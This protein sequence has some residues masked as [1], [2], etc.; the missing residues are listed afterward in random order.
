VLI[1]LRADLNDMVLA[2]LRPR[3]MAGANARRMIVALALATLPAVV[4]GFAFKDAV[5]TVLR[6]P[7]L[8]AWTTVG[9]GVVLYAADRTMAR[10]R[11]LAEMT[12]PAALLIGLAQVIAIVP[13]VSRS[14]ITMTAARLLGLARPAAA[15][16]S[17][18]LSIPTIGG[19][20]LLG[21][22]DIAR[23][24]QPFL[25]ADAA[26]G[27]AIAFVA[28]LASMGALMRWV[29][30]RSFLPFV[31]YRI[32]LGAFLFAWLYA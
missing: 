28:A 1:Y 29:E 13:G 14:G 2:L 5:A 27:A 15:R 31:L 20:C 25:F 10:A 8:I 24:P 30:R 23:E 7:L 17:F 12:L 6:S 21:A 11:T 16:F 9:F 22:L 4:A 32:A 18:L 19:A 26:L 3:D